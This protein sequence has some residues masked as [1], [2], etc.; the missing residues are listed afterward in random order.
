MVRVALLQATTLAVL[1]HAPQVRADVTPAE[2]TFAQLR[3]SLPDGTST[4]VSLSLSLNNHDLSEAFH[5]PVQLGDHVHVRNMYIGTPQGFDYL[6][7]TTGNCERNL[8]CVS[9][10]M[11]PDRVQGSGTWRISLANNQTHTLG[12]SLESGVEVHLQNVRRGPDGPQPMG[13]LDNREAGCEGNAICVTAS[14]NP[15]RDQGSGTWELMRVAGPGPIY[16]GD[17]LH[18]RNKYRGFLGGTY[19]DV[20]NGPTNGGC[21]SNRHCVSGAR[22]PNR[23]RN[24]GTWT[25]ALPFV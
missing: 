7:T 10:S 12:A 9:A 25:F 14:S 16:Y 19:L 1:L 6:D 22:L 11:S 24:S 8:Q 21:E 4:G 20:R 13:Y 17:E 3:G 5:V 18:L 23:F 2:R 15:D